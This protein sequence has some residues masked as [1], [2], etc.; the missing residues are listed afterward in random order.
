MTTKTKQ[1]RLKD[2]QARNLHNMSYESK[3]IHQKRIK[4]LKQAIT[5]DKNPTKDSTN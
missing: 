3:R 2:L 5:E 4:A 1:Q